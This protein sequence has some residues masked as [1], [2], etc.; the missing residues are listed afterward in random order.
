MPTT[1]DDEAYR[2]QA[3]FGLSIIHD[4]QIGWD[5]SKASFI[6]ALVTHVLDNDAADGLPV[7]IF[8]W[9]DSSDE[10]VRTDGVVAAMGEVQV[11]LKGDVVIDVDDIISFHI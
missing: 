8:H 9:N 6:R 7:R 11:H 2:F 5:E 10:V 1:T 3:G 4:S